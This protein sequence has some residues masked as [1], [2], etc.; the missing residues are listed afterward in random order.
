MGYFDYEVNSN[1]G[2]ERYSST[3]EGG[4]AVS[5]LYDGYGNRKYL[6]VAE[7][8]AFL[9]AAKG[10]P[11][12]VRSFCLTLSYTGA[13]ISEVL[14]LTPG[15]IDFAAKLII[16]ESLKK[17]RRGGF[18]AVPIPDAVLA[19]LDSVHNARAAQ[20]D[21]GLSQQKLWPW[22]RTTAWARVKECMAIAQVVGPQASPKGLRHAFAVGALQAGVPI[23]FVKKWLGHARLST[24]EIYADAVGDEE[25]SIAARFWKTF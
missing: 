24:T 9:V 11:A 12:D 5:F 23:N 3:S 7:R 2:S 18:R 16:I 21:A 19:E 17:R 10:L 4:A 8:T 14:S 25:S 6:T 22:C 13:R 1:N 20:R 15:R